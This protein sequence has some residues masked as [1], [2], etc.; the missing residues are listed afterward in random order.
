MPDQKY[1]ILDEN[2]KELT[3]EEVDRELGYTTMDKIFKQHHEA[4]PEKEYK[5]HY[6]VKTWYFQDD[7]SMDVTGNDDPHVKVID[8]EAGVFGYVDQGEGKVYRGG[9]LEDVI[10]QE[11][12]DAKEA[13]DEYEDII[14]YKLFTEEEL[15][16]NKEQKEKMEKQQAFMEDGPDQLQTNTENIDDLY[17]TIADVVA[18]SEA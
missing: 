3:E 1:R 13:Y 9:A 14:R 16:N 5:H 4:V 6:V 17:I 15:K 18:G 12:E 11:H 10:D 2:D 7:T 8:E